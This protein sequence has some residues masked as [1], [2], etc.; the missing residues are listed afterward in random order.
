MPITNL[1][2]WQA[3]PALAELLKERWPVKTSYSLAKL[4]QKLAKRHALIETVRANLIRQHGT[5]NGDGQIAVAPDSPVWN[6]FATAFNE[7]ME[8]ETDLPDTRIVLPDVE[9]VSLT[10]AQLMDLEPFIEMAE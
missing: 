9:G 1:D 6:D 3:K 5:A 7:L 2:V 8:T 10:P 4:A